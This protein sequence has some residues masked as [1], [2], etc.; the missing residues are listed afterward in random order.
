MTPVDIAIVGWA[1]ATLGTSAYALLRALLRGRPPRSLPEMPAGKVLLIRPCAGD[2]ASLAHTLGSTVLAGDI[3]RSRV[4]FAIGHHGDPSR[5]AAERARDRLRAAGVEAHV[6]ITSA[7]GLNHKVAQLSRALARHGDGCDYVVVAD[8]DVDLSGVPLRELIAPIAPGSPAGAAWSPVVESPFAPTFADRLSQVVLGG[9]LH[10]FP[11]LAELDPRTMV[12]KLFAIRLDALE[13]VGG[14]RSLEAFLGED[15]ELSRRLRAAGIGVVATRVTAVARTA[16]R[17]L[18]AVVGRFARWITVVRAQRPGLL[19]TYPL[20]FC[21]LP[22]VL[23]AAWLAGAS[24]VSALGAFALVLAGR[25]LAAAAAIRRAPSERFVGAPWWWLAADL[26]LLAAF[27][28][29]LATRTVSWRGRDLLVG[30]RGV[31]ELTS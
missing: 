17:S 14:L 10:A 9:S 11:V 15:A 22:C 29:A 3:E 6:E 18:G 8:S 4:V 7:H 26:V 13:A 12:G 19:P 23:L 25:G 20:L 1:S 30:R 28:R 16:G 27:A 31:L 24:A 2:E 21:A 5:P